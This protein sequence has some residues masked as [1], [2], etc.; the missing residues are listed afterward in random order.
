NPAPTLPQSISYAENDAG[1]VDAR[2]TL[3]G[4]DTVLDRKHQVVR[5]PSSAPRSCRAYEA[6]HGQ[7]WRADHQTE[8]LRNTFLVERVTAGAGAGGVGVVD[9]EALLLDRKSTRLN[10]SH[11][12]SSY[13]VV[14]L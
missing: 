8:S 3:P 14:I 12:S 10:F 6:V 5:S 13:V 9:G 11:G 4:L 2:S 1:R 7:R